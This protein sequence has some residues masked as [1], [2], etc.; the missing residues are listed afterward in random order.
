VPPGCAGSGQDA[1]TLA[2]KVTTDAAAT[3]TYRPAITVG[4]VPAAVDFSV[5]NDTTGTAIT[6]FQCPV[7]VQFE[8]VPSGANVAFWN[9]TTWVVT[10][11]C[12]FYTAGGVNGAQCSLDHLSK[13]SVITVQSAGVSAPISA[14]SPGG[15]GPGGAVTPGAAPPTQTFDASAGGKVS[16]GGVQVTIPGGSVSEAGPITASIEGVLLTPS[17]STTV[18]AV[19]SAPVPEGMAFGSVAF[20]FTLTGPSGPVTLTK[21]VTMT[22]PYAASDVTLAGGSPSG[23][24]LMHYDPTAQRWTDLKGSAAAGTV[25]APAQVTGLFSLIVE[26]PKPALTSPPAEFV[27]N[28][29][30]PLLEWRN[31]AGTTQYQIQVIPFN[32]DGP[33]INLIRNAESSYQV[34][35]PAFGTGPYVM[36]PGMTYTWR[37]RTATAATGLAEN[38]PGWSG[39]ASDTFKTASTTSLFIRPTGPA[40]GGEVPS[41][42]PTIAWENGFKHIFYYEVQISKDPKFG[43]GAFLYWE[44]RHGGATT[45]PN[46][47]RIPEQ[48]PLEA[49]TIY[50]WRVRPRVQGDG[51]PVEWSDVWTFK[52]PGA[53]Q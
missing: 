18:A 36:L 13:F 11:S 37:V 25:T 48:F 21:P 15:G 35:A 39:W 26:L 17:G 2:L 12:A 49:A 34:Q 53:G 43:S 29:L 33:G 10:T 1:I 14:P 38:D 24:K 32:N 47:Y 31:P 27:S 6:Q 42:T 51:T 5:T 50:Y 52:T 46:T 40:V 28:D 4:G 8:P 44:L 19:A 7:E 9:G 22:V 16:A 45:P 30:A 41:L 23:I 3:A 20:S